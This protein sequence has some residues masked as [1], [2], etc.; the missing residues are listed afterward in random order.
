MKRQWKK[1]YLA[2]IPEGEIACKGRELQAL[3]S[4]RYGVYRKPYPP[5]H[6]TVGIITFPREEIM[7]IIE[8]IKVSVKPYLPVDL[9][10]TGES[11]FPQPYKSLNLSIETT[12]QLVNLSETIK[13]TVENTGF[14]AESFESWDYHI[15]LVNS[16]YAAREWRDEEYKE[17]C[18]FLTRQNIRLKGGARRLEMWEPD[19]PPLTIAARFE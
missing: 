16:N 11:C 14:I 6:V 2:A 4:N 3:F 13:E 5:L 7:T 9:L 17:A 18:R 1:Y 12:K 10:S 19:F 8:A 15:S